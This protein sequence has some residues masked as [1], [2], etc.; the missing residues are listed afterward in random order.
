MTIRF[1]Q[2]LRTAAMLFFFPLSLLGQD[3][4][5]LYKVTT[6]EGGKPSYLF[7]TIHLLPEDRFMFTDK[8]AEAFDATE[9]LV[10]EM[11]LD[12]P[13][14]QQLAMAKE[15]MMPDGKSWAD[16][17]TP[18]EFALIRSA[19]V[20]SLGVKANKFD[21]QYI[22]IKPMYLSGLVLTQLL[23]NV[24]AYEQELSAKAKKAKKPIIGL[25][26][27]EQQMSFMASVTLE[28]QISQVKEAGAS[29]LREYNR[30]LEAYL[31]QDLTTLEAL[32][33]ESGD[34]EGME[35]ELLIKRNQAW[36]PLMLNQMKQSPTFFA[37]G[38]LHLVGEN[39]VIEKL[40][41][42]GVNVEAIN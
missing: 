13:M 4:S 9:T 12:I 15:M 32:A 16:F 37:V 5:L 20:D 23:G 31:S 35:Q 7:G 1:H 19:Y 26:T 39:G 41:A 3:A 29:L 33:R 28:D 18:D 14:G 25:E 34:L 2:P 24:K 10:L 11:T 42:A 36:I 30:M 40:R 6:A 21:K 27:L 38:A 22:K 17:M 8:M